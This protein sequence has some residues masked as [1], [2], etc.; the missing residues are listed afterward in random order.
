MEGFTPNK[1][2]NQSGCPAYNS[3]STCYIYATSFLLKNCFPPRG[4][5]LLGRSDWLGL[6]IWSKPLVKLPH[7]LVTV[8][9]PW[10]QCDSHWTNQRPF[11]GSFWLVLW[12]EN[13]FFPLRAMTLW[14]QH[15]PW[16]S[17]S[18]QRRLLTATECPVS[19]WR[20]QRDEWQ[21]HLHGIRCLGP[22]DP[23]PA[24]SICP[25]SWVEFPCTPQPCH[26]LARVRS[27]SG[28]TKECYCRCLNLGRKVGGVWKCGEEGSFFRYCVFQFYS[29]HLNPFFFFTVSR[30]GLNFSPSMC[31]VYYTVFTVFT[32]V[33]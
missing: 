15:W 2:I 12:E 19:F 21:E 20:E 27:L 1:S 14:A 8:I 28:S 17:H 33:I 22:A 13:L 11:P 26:K 29:F 16:P 30:S 9:G 24:H 25:H 31:L 3:S 5:C 10:R 6:D 32:E 4:N 7:T 23:E 18:T